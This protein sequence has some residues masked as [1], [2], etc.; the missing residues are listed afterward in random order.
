MTMHS[1]EQAAIEQTEVGK[2]TFFG[3]CADPRTHDTFSVNIFQVVAKARGG[4]KK[5]KGVYRVS[6]L[7]SAPEQVYSDAQAICD[8]LNKLPAQTGEAR[9]KAVA[10]AVM[11]KRR[12]EQP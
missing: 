2:W 5:S 3:A 8:E 7:T 1:S 10:R 9:A 11:F 6:G 12:R 4:K